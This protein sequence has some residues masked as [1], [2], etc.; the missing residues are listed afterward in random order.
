MVFYNDFVP[1]SDRTYNY[2]NGLTF[3]DYTLIAKKYFPFMLDLI[4]FDKTNGGEYE[5][6]LKYMN[7]ISWEF[8]DSQ[9]GGRGHY[10]NQAQINADDRKI[11]FSTLIGHLINRRKIFSNN[12]L[13][14]LDALAG[15]GTISRYIKLENIHG[16]EI[17]SSD[18]S[19]YMIKACLNEK[20][21]CIRQS[22]CKT[23]LKSSSVD[24]VLIAYGSHHLD[25]ASRKQAVQEAYRIIKPGGCLVMHDFEIGSPVEKWFN[26]VV[27]PYSNTGHPHRHF[28]RVEMID[29][30]S[31]AGFIDVEVFNMSDHI[32]VKG[33]SLQE[34]RNNCLM[35]LYLMYGLEKISIETLD[36]LKTLE[37][38]VKSTLGEI[39]YDRHDK[40]YTAT[41]M[42]EA[43]VV[44]GLRP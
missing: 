31:N 16:L 14:I 36:K 5:D 4:D 24:G 34:A 12:K 28:T 18:L 35:H 37:N 33:N 10:Y 9:R 19:S 21:P 25:Q 11:G 43:L 20:I 26:N 42:R 1:R 44:L 41:V 40:S 8:E 13:I 6:Y 29:L 22:I 27:H 2:I 30:L 17:I 15:N 38:L 32:A 3:S 23:L 39:L 7:C